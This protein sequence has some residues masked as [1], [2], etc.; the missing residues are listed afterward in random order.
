MTLDCGEVSVVV[1]LFFIGAFALQFLM[2]NR[3][4]DDDG[5]INIRFML[6][7]YWLCESI[8]A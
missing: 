7:N 5:A 4:N 8:L 3:V 6:A 1:G 2:Q